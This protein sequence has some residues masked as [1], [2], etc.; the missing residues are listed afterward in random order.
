M[1]PT[2]RGKPVCSPPLLSDVF[3]VLPLKNANVGL[4]DDGPF[5]S[6]QGRS[7]SVSS[8]YAF[9][10]QAIDGVMTLALYR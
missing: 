10:L 3:S 5:S 7:S 2:R 8:F 4:I 9:L 1:A 6:F